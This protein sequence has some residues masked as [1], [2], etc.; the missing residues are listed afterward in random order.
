[1]ACPFMR[2]AAAAFKG[3]ARRLAVHGAVRAGMPV[4]AIVEG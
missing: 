1:M 4:I 2:C 3:A